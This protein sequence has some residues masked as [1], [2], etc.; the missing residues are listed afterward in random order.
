MWNYGGYVAEEPKKVTKQDNSI[1]DKHGTKMT[2]LF[3]GYICDTCEPPKKA[4]SKKALTW[5]EREEKF[6]RDMFGRSIRKSVP[7]VPNTTGHRITLKG[8]KNQ[9]GNVVTSAPTPSPATGT[10]WYTY[11]SKGDKDEV[12]GYKAYDDLAY[13]KGKLTRKA[14]KA[15]KKYYLYRLSGD[16]DD[17][18]IDYSTTRPSI[19]GEAEVEL[20]WET[21]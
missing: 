7:P 10:T 17:I 2:L 6:Q 12:E 8:T 5:E 1:C 19:D 16:P 14:A 3:T 11:S 18:V 21:P 13:L 15:G 9:S 4:T 20:E